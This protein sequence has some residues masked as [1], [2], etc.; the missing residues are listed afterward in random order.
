MIRD[1][2]LTRIRGQRHY[3]WRALDQD[4]DVI[5]ILLTKRRD[6]RSS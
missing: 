2:V 4:A 6:P 3:L 5:D 1:E